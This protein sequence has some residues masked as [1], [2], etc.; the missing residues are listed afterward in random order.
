MIMTFEMYL[1]FDGNLAIEQ[2]NKAGEKLFFVVE[3]KRGYDTNESDLD[4]CDDEAEYFANLKQAIADK[5]NLK[6]Y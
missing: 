5:Y 6:Q 2:K 3:I 4:D 1:D